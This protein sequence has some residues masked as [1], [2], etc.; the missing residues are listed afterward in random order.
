MLLSVAS[1][2]ILVSEVVFKEKH[3][4]V[5]SN[6]T[7]CPNSLSSLHTHYVDGVANNTKSHTF[8]LEA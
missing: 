7:L 4:Q 2:V 3:H 5:K 8:N 6:H 1:A